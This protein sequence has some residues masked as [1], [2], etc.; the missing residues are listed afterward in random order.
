M[1]SVSDQ[2]RKKKLGTPIV[3]KQK[4]RLKIW[5]KA[6]GLWKSRKPDPLKE[7]KKMREDW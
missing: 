1:P 2:R 3:E 6:K 7:L 5:R 4:N